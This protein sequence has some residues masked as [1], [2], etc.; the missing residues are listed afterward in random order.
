[1]RSRWMRSIMITSAS[2]SPSC[3]SLT[4]SAPRSAKCDGTSVVG[5]T[6]RTRAPIVRSPNRFERATRLCS[7]SPTIATVKP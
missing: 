6:K 2:R 5:P 3:R 1:M 7:R 4:S